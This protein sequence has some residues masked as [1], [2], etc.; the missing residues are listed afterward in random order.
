MD[1]YRCTQLERKR[2]IG[3]D[4]VNIVFLDG[5]AEDMA[6]FSPN[7]IKSQFTRKSRYISALF[8]PFC[9]VL[10]WRLTTSRIL[11]VADIFALVT[12]NSTDDSYRFH[13]YSEESVP[14]FGPSLPSP[15]VFIRVAEFREFLLV[16]RKFAGRQI[17]IYVYNIEWRGYVLEANSS[18]RRLLFRAIDPT[19]NDEAV[20]YSALLAGW[21]SASLLIDLCSSTTTTT[22]TTPPLL[23]LHRSLQYPFMTDAPT[24]CASWL[25]STVLTCIFFLPFSVRSFSSHQRGKGRIQYAH[26]LAETRENARHAHQGHVRWSNDRTPRGTWRKYT[27]TN[28]NLNIY[29]SVAS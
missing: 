4:I 13:I 6:N 2:H 23:L 14:L 3:N 18:H 19:S 7:C 24:L 25:G 21:I 16:K 11:G 10:F 15:P 26:L 27:I 17:V 9:S 1:R 20:L 29:Y 12:Y 5:T 28:C 22:T 8:C